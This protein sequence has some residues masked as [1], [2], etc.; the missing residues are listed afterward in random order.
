MLYPYKRGEA[1][2]LLAD[3]DTFATVIMA[4]LLPQYGDALF[5]M[6][7]ALLFKTIEEDFMCKLSEESENRINA[8][9]TCMT[10]DLFYTNLHMFKSIALAFNEGDI[11]G[12]PDGEDEELDAGEALWAMM[13]AS[14]LTDEDDAPRKE[15]SKE[16]MQYVDSLIGALADDEEDIDDEVDTVEEALQEPY[17]KSV[18]KENCDGVV[19]QLT[20]LGMK[21]DDVQEMFDNSIAL[22][23]Q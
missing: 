14:L 13:E 6:D 8:A 21:K 20:Q 18:L 4:I 11:G 23:V 5:E 16:I 12:I 1:A 22:A 7:S 3:D 9:I 17:F 19:S 15:Y 2:K 10:T